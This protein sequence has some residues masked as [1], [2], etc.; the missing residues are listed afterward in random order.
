MLE[1]EVM[2]QKRGRDSMNLNLTDHIS[3]VENSLASDLEH[4]KTH[5]EKKL[6]EGNQNQQ[7]LEDKVSHITRELESENIKMKQNIV[8]L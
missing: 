7:L 1:D 4:V 5:V 6:A 8:D 2:K 3:Q